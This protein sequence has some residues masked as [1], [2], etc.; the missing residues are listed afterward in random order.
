MGTTRVGTSGWSYRH[1]RDRFYPRGL[2]QSKW[3]EH[4]S[5]VFGTVELNSPFYRLPERRTFESWASRVPGDFLFAVK[6]SRYITHV[7]RARGVAEP[8]GAMLDCYAGLYEKLGP[9]LFQFP[10]DWS[11]DLARLEELLEAVPDAYRCAYEFRDPSWFAQETYAR[12]ER[13]GA[14]LCIA[15]STRFPKAIEVTAPFTYI[16]MHGSAQP[17]GSKYSERELRQWA[18]RIAHDFA[19]AGLEVYVYFNNDACGYAVD[20]ALRLKELLQQ[21]AT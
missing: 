18:S 9:I 2:R 12:L 14:A 10:P 21:Q 15:D 7:K 6:A 17:Y 11:L 19:G 13:H 8:L 5:S 3:L 1:W 16:R 20:N 4:Y